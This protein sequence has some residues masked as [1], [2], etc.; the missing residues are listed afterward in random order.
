MRYDGLRGMRLL[1]ISEIQSQRYLN[2]QRIE[3]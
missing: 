1:K 2:F 3:K